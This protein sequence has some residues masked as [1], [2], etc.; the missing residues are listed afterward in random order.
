MDNEEVVAKES[1]DGAEV[2]SRIETVY[3]RRSGRG[4]E[5]GEEKV[6]AA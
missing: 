4:G 5:R 1:D 3:N 6:V 2:G